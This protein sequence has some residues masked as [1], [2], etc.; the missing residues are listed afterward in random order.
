MAADDILWR[1]LLTLSRRPDLTLQ[2]QLRG[3]VAQAVLDRRLPPGT[4]LPSSR[5]LAE[6]LGISR[7]T[8]ILAYDQLT[9]EGFVAARSRSR[10]MV[11]PAA[12]E[13]AARAAGVRPD[14]PAR[15]P[16]WTARLTGRPSRTRYV[17]KPVDWYN[18]RFPF[19]YGQPDPTLFPITE[20]REVVQLSLRSVAIR[21]WAGD[22]VDADDPLLIEQ[23]QKRVLPRRGIWVSPEQ[24][25][26]TLGAQQALYLAASL[27]LGPEKTA[28][29]EQPG[30]PD[31]RNLCR[32]FGARVQHLPMDR[33]GLRP[34]AGLAGCDLLFVQPS[35]QNPTTV[36]MPLARRQELLEA[37]SA[38]DVIVVEDDYDSELTF[39]GEATPALKALDRDDRVIYVGSVSKTL[40][41]GLRLGFVV[42]A[43]EFIA[44]ARAMRRL[45]AR[46]PP[47]NNQRAVALFLQLGHHDAAIKR[48]IAAYR[49]RAAAIGEGLRTYLPEFD[50]R[51]PAGGSALWAE[52]PADVSMNAVAAAAAPQG[53]LFDPGAVFFDRPVPPEN[54]VRLGY[55]A[56]PLDR[57]EPGIQLMA[58]LVRAA[59][60][61][62]RQAGVG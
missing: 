35:H 33:H 1:Q 55:S 4:E 18:Y 37:A 41:P 25:L 22:H 60:H 46:H 21:D 51:L 50:F 36:T 5:R 56:I 39:V 48:L 32:Q 16:D 6:I 28:A 7:N 12:L 11:D 47:A 42:A 15:R 62:T 8:V 61:G 19:V 30:Y 53:L 38:H 2:A 3:A 24:I 10:H 29:I 34:G 45:T 43:P 20:W 27:L 58:R 57:I 49:E 40:A 9:Q 26:V 44:E 59:R 52:G 54:V 23:L 13:N 31:I 14:A 17:T